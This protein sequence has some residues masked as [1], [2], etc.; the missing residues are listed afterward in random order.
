MGPT[1]RAI[2]L[3]TGHLVLAMASVIAMLVIGLAYAGLAY[4]GRLQ[5]F[6]QSRSSPQPV[7]TVDLNMVSAARELEPPLERLFTDAADRRLAAQSLFDFILSERNSG[8]SL[9]NV[10]TILR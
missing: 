4:A 1:D 6:D 10:G 5:T 8:Y 9:P 3:H 7:R 2:R